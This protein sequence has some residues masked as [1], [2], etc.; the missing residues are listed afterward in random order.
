M[1]THFTRN[2]IA[3][4]FVAAQLRNLV[5]QFG[6]QIITKPPINKILFNFNYLLLDCSAFLV[7]ACGLHNKDCVFRC[8]GNVHWREEHSSSAADLSG[9]N[10]REA[11]GGGRGMSHM[12]LIS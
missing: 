3:Q 1:S 5:E 4:Q 10:V 7:G 2:L 6:F 9:D 12:T 11:W 8:L